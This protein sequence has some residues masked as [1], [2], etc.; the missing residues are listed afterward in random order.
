MKKRRNDSIVKGKSIKDIMSIDPKDILKMNRKELSIYTSRL[1]SAA[2]KR[3]KRMYGKEVNKRDYKKIKF[4]VKGKNINQ[5]R[6]EYARAKSYLQSN[7]SLS[8]MKKTK[9]K[10]I[11][12]LKK[13]GV[14]ITGKQYNKFWSVYQRLKEV[15]P[16]VS[17]YIYKYMSMRDIADYINDNPTAS[18]DEV[19]DGMMADLNRHYEEQKEQEY[20][21]GFSEFFDDK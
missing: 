21:G 10:V 12:G 20:D 14:K 2:N 19:I 13:Q 17:S 7:H 15:D 18:I 9:K 5:L 1:A 8:G 3:L 16:K 11:S 6:A 4:S